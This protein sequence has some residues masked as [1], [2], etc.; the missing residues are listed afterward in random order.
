[1]YAARA[2]LV[3]GALAGKILR[4]LLRLGPAAALAGCG[5]AL[6]GGLQTGQVAVITGYPRRPSHWRFRSMTSRTAW[7]SARCSCLLRHQFTATSLRPP[8]RL[9]AARC[10][11]RAHALGPPP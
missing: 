6:S 10:G 7:A 2:C 5:D 1:M 4:G 9:F 11:G 3:G 8:V